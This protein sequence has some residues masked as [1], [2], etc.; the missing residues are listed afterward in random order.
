VSDSRR[1]LWC[2]SRVGLAVLVFAV[3]RSPVTDSAGRFRLSL[4]RGR[5]ALSVSALGYEGA[6]RTVE[7]QGSD[8]LEVEIELRVTAVMLDAIVVTGLMRETTVSES[9]AKVEV[10]SGRQLQR[11]VA[12]NLMEVIGHVNGLYAQVDC[13]VCYKNNI[14]INGMEGPY[15]AVLI[16]G[17]PIMGGLASV[18]GL[19]G[20][21]P[22]LVEQ[23]EILKGP[24]STLYGTEAMGGVV[25]VITKSPRFAPRLVIDGNRSS[26]G[27]TNVN[28]AASFRGDGLGGLLSATATRADARLDAN[29]DGFTDSPLLDR[30]AVFGKLEWRR[31]GERRGML[32]AK[33]YREDRFGGQLGWSDSDRGSSSVYGEWVKTRR[34]EL[35]GTIRPSGMEWLSADVSLS[36]HD[37]ECWYGDV[38]YDARQAIAWGQV[39]WRA[40]PGGHDLLAGAAIRWQTYNDDTPETGEPERQLIPGLFVQDEFD[41]GASLT[42]V[43]GMRVDHHEEHGGI[44]S[45]RL[46]VLW[47]P[48]DETQVRLNAGNDRRGCVPHAIHE[49]DRA[50]YD[51]DP[52]LIVYG[53]LRGHSVSRGFAFSLKSELRAVPAAIH[54]GRDR[55]G[56]AR[57]ARWRRAGR[58][59]FAIVEG[60]ARADVD[61]R[62]ACVDARLDRFVRRADAAAG[63]RSAVRAADPVTGALGAQSASGTDTGR[64]RRDLRG[65]EQPLRFHAGLA[66]GGSGESVG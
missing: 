65:G 47:R 37:Q 55:A 34:A 31:E 36:I 14:R 28:A 59:P 16:D 57:D 20:I 1:G 53:N 13:G 8:W 62:A 58:D 52:A 33:V 6:R 66:A 54:G 32:T 25:N 26:G 27:E 51:A 7:V 44:V 40:R 5:H 30:V 49:A 56:R 38:R 41:I 45:S 2:I 64:W 11:T 12:S 39:T 21:D 18:Y 15:T 42:V 61:V 17:M 50:D 46:N 4:P 60:S 10:V 29:A 43:G 35:L 24:A 63:I 23:L 22:G 3:V 48:F 9:S 19:N